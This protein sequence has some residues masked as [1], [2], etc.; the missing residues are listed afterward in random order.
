MFNEILFSLALCSI[1]GLAQPTTWAWESKEPRNQIIKVQAHK[2]IKSVDC[3]FDEQSD[4]Y[5]YE[6]DYPSKRQAVLRVDYQ[7]KP[8]YE[9]IV[10]YSDG[11]VDKFLIPTP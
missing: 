4:C 2:D 10:E 11:S 7:N 3:V 5:A 8:T 6:I 1:S 9:M